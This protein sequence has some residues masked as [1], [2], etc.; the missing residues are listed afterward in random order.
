MLSNNAQTSDGVRD[1]K[2]LKL[3]SKGLFV[4]S[5]EGA[6]NIM[7]LGEHGAMSP[8]E[9]TVRDEQLARELQ[10][11]VGCEVKLEYAEFLTANP[12][13]YDSSYN[14]VGFECQSHHVSGRCGG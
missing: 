9:F 7:S 13:K 11:H 1:A 5:W 8:W 6:L 3:S 10:T 2:L 14:V 4:K 12:M